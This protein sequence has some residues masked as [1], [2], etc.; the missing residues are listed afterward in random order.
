MWCYCLACSLGSY[1]NQWI[2]QEDGWD[3]GLPPTGR[4]NGGVRPKVG[5]DLRPRR[6][7]MVVEYIATRPITDLCLAAERCLGTRLLNLW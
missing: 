3:V 5:G 7:N 1:Q 6:Y 4:V 2:K